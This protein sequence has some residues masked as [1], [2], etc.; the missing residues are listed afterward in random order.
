MFW[1]FAYNFTD[2]HLI[3]MDEFI[4]SLLRDERACDIILPRIQVRELY[5]SYKIKSHESPSPFI[6]NTIYFNCNGKSF[7]LVKVFS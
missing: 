1:G 3:H 4:D 6:I 2:F 7:S 5:N